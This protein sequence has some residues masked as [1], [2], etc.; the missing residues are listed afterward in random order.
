MDILTRFCAMFTKIV[1]NIDI[2]NN[3]VYNILVFIN[4]L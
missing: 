2:K 1:K 4:E 3:L